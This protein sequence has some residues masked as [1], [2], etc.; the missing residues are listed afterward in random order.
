MGGLAVDGK[1]DIVEG[2]AIGDESAGC[3]M[4]IHER[5]VQTY[6]DRGGVAG[7]SEDKA[8]RGKMRGRDKMSRLEG[9]GE[10][11]IEECSKKVTSAETNYRCA[12]GE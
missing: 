8:G 11:K 12:S 9:G 6:N 7:D 3:P 10:E 5:Q 4:S 2:G 1:I